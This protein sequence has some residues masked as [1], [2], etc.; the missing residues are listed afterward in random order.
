MKKPLWQRNYWSDADWWDEIGDPANKSR[1]VLTL[2]TDP[3]EFGNNTLAGEFWLW[4]DDNRE[5]LGNFHYDVLTSCW[6]NEPEFQHLNLTE[7]AED[8]SYITVF[9]FPT[10]QAATLFKLGFLSRI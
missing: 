2:L 9:L 3:Y 5:A 6:F 10:D 4:A 8:S 1:V 7:I